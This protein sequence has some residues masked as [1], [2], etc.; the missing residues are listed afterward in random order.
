M[1]YH[2]PNHYKELELYLT[3]ALIADAV[4]FILYLIVAACAI[5]WLKVITAF[6][7]MA[8]AALIIYYLYVSKELRRQRSLWIT[9]GAGSVFLCTLMSL[10]LNFPCPAP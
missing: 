4:L 1:M 3:C 10:V 9:V 5:I 2:K 7:S 6:L 8:L